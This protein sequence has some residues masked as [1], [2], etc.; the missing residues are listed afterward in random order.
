MSESIEDSKLERLAERGFPR[1]T[2]PRGRLL[3]VVEV[4]R[5]FTDENHG[6]SAKEIARAVGFLTGKE[7]SENTVLADLHTLASFQP[8]DMKIAAP[9][10]G[11]NTGFRCV[12]KHLTSDEAILVG[13]IVRASSFIGSE[14]RR[15]LSEKLYGLSS[16]E[17][18]DKSADTVFVDEVEGLRTSEI[19]STINAAG[20]AIRTGKQL[21]FR[22]RQHWM[23]GEEHLSK[24]R[25][26]DPVA[27]VFSFGRYYLETVATHPETGSPISL[28]TRVDDMREARPSDKDH[29]YPDLVKQL[30][31]TVVKDTRAKIDMYGDGIMRSLFLKVDGRSAG[32]VYDRFGHDLKFE[33][34]EEKE[35]GAVGY[36]HINVQLSPTFFRWL[37]GHGRKIELAKPRSIKWVKQFNGCSNVDS[38]EFYMLIEDYEL[39]L[40]SYRAELERALN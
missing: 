32:Y 35:D 31:R 33:H 20:E 11:E 8:F 38:R 18:Y 26:E 5:I 24:I 2:T 30:E 28:L 19:L 29:A 25:Q 37:F 13:D 22:K 9:S 39:T 7:P 3:T 21:L 4:L 34:V 15:D 1:D 6:L 40:K 27:I 36:A 17:R 12:Q 23:N 16:V 10:H 14:T